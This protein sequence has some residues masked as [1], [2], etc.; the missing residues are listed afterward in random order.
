[1]IEALVLL[2]QRGIQPGLT[3]IGSGPERENLE[4]LVR[5]KHLE[6]Q[7][8]FPGSRSGEELVR[9]LNEHRIMVI[10]SRWNEPFGVVALEGIACGCVVVGSS[11]GGLP[12]AIGPCGVTFPNGDAQALGSA[13]SNLLSGPDT[14]DIYRQEA[15]QHLARHEAAR[16]S[17]DY[18]RNFQKVANNE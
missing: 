12:E 18:L 2:R 9:L 3:L 17:E 7:V 1:L 5:E 15:A 6:A 8:T 4:R 14:L 13:L 11:G 16:V 10:P